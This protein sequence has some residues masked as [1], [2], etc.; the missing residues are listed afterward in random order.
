MVSHSEEN[1][2]DFNVAFNSTYRYLNNSEKKKKKKK[3]G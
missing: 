3:N 2:A 1:D